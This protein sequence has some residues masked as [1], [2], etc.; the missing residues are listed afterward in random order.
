[1]WADTPWGAAVTAARA[2]QTETPCPRARAA[3]AADGN[4]VPGCPRRV[5]G[6]LSPVSDG[7]GRA[8][9]FGEF[10]EAFG[11]AAGY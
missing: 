4:G 1:M 11:L 10:G 9:E 8:V 7:G 3:S 5:R 2:W 6:R